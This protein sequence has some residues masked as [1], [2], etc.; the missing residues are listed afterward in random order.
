MINTERT[1]PVVVIPERL[2]H[3][4]PWITKRKQG[5]RPVWSAGRCWWIKESFLFGR[6]ADGREGTAPFEGAREHKDSRNHS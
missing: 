6:P 4:G 5:E 3:V 1:L 2:S